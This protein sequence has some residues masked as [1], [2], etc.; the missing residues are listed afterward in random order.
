MVDPRVFW[1]PPSCATSSGISLSSQCD[2]FQGCPSGLEGRW[3]WDV[4]LVSRSFIWCFQVVC[5]VTI[6]AIAFLQQKKTPQCSSSQWCGNTRLYCNF[7]RG[8]LS[9]YCFCVSLS[10]SVHAWLHVQPHRACLL[11]LTFFWCLL[12]LVSN[13]FNFSVSVKM[14]FSDFL[15][16]PQLWLTEC[17]V[18]CVF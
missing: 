3:Y 8:F 2:D 1:L 5:G 15:V 9:G 13:I 4:L 10:S 17:F 11:S 12:Q 18:C 6:A 7:P 14:F 16:S